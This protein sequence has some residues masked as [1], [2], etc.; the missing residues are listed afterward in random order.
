MIPLILLLPLLAAGEEQCP[1]SEVGGFLKRPCDDGQFQCMASNTTYI[2]F[3]TFITRQFTTVVQ[4]ICP[5]DPSNYQACLRSAEMVNQAPHCGFLCESNLEDFGW[6][7]GMS[8]CEDHGVMES[9]RVGALDYITRTGTTCNNVCD[10]SMDWEKEHEE[11][12]NM[13]CLEELSCNNCQI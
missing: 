13:W 7:I 1:I 8:P 10:G 5:N 12:I 2:K 3:N 4:P 11:L 9:V 6:L